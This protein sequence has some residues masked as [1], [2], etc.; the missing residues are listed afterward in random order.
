MERPRQLCLDSHGPRRGIALVLC[1]RADAGERAD[2]R[3]GERT[4]GLTRER[5]R[6]GK[7]PGWQPCERPGCRAM[8]AAVRVTERAGIAYK[9]VCVL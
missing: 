3:I 7:R 8:T 6:A 5:G 2:R 4:G 1:V 9:R